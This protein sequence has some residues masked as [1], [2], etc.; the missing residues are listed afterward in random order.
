MIRHRWLIALAAIAT[1]VV[2]VAADADARAGGGFSGGSRGT[3]TFSAPPPTRTAPNTAAPI[4][5]SVTQPGSP[6]T[7]GQAAARPGL[8]G[9]GLFG[10]GLLGGLAAGFIGAGLFGMLFG[11]G[12]FGGMAGFASI[13]GLL[14]QVVLVIVVARLTLCLVAAAQCS[15]GARL[16]RGAPGHRS[17]LRRPGRFGGMLGRQCA[18][19]RAADHRQT[20]LRRV[21]AIARRHPGRLFGGGSCRRCAPR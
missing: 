4:Q 8:L 13:L 14:L 21:R 17:R 12:M 5:R 10:G 15:A 19:R 16:C 7:V 2:L 3:R 1:A 6:S 20:G 18:G 9:G 11:H